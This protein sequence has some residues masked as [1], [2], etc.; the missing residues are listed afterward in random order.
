MKPVKA[1]AIVNDGKLY[2]DSLGFA[3]CPKPT[4]F[5]KSMGTPVQV[6]I[7]EIREV[8]PKKRKP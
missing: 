5:H 6:E 8:K 4:D 2:V 1:W 7:R 3:I